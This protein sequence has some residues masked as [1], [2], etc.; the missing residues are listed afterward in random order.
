MKRS[1]LSLSAV[2]HCR[3]VA[4][5]SVTLDLGGVRITPVADG[6]VDMPNSV[7]PDF[8]PDLAG[9][10]VTDHFRHYISAFLVCDGQRTL[11]VDTGSAGNFGPNAGRFG[12]SLAAAGIVPEAV[13]AIMLTHLHSDHYGGLTT[14][15][16]AAVFP[17]ARLLVPAEEWRVVH[18]ANFFDALPKSE[19]SIVMQARKAVAAYAGRTVLV[20]GGDTIGQGLA[21]LALPGHTP[22]HM[23]LTIQG[24]TA[25]AIVVGDMIHC[26]QYQAACPHWSVVYDHDLAQ[27]AATRVSIFARAADE[28][29]L[30]LGAHLGSGT[31]FR[32]ER[33]GAGFRLRDQANPL[34]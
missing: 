34:P 23:G 17:R 9:A 21:A 27:A 30:V 22:G 15:A 6:W 33:A 13:D 14:P 7:F 3:G 1:S 19:T 20:Q 8:D 29:W 25:K 16:G 11:L 24:A 4:G 26:G 32:V 12:Q 2:A 5:L 28:D 10:L 18:D 31:P